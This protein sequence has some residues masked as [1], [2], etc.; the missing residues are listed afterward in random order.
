LA[1]K[2]QYLAVLRLMHRNPIVRA[3]YGKT[4]AARGGKQTM[5]VLIGI[6]RKLAASLYQVAQGHAFDASKLFDVRR[7]ELKAS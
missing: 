7:L 4:V 3:Y 1:R 6:M 5:Q 2:Y